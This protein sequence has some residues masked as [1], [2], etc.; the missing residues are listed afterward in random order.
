MR[1]KYLGSILEDEV[2]ETFDGREIY[3]LKVH[4]HHCAVYERYRAT[5]DDWKWNLRTVSYLRN[6]I[7]TIIEM[8]V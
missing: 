4:E 2:Y 6:N 3:I 1:D 7:R 5:N 8:E